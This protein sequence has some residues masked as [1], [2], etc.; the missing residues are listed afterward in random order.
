MPSLKSYFAKLF[1]A[2]IARKINAWAQD[3]L[4]T[5]ERV[6]KSLIKSASQTTFGKDH[7][8]SQI[9]THDDFVSRVPIRDYEALRPY[10]ERVINGESDILWSGKP[11]Y[12][13]KTS[14]PLPS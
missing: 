7:A 12:F 14:T 3:P 9:K 10:V 1:A 13:A 4:Q 6:F 11:L 5:Q 8:F 2:K